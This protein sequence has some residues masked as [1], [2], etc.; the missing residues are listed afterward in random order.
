MNLNFVEKKLFNFNKSIRKYEEFYLQ[1]K[2][3]SRVFYPACQKLNLI[4]FEV[5]LMVIYHIAW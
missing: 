1:I 3:I 5:L 2:K 4:Y